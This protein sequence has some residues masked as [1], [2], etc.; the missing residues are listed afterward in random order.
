[1]PALATSVTTT[2]THTV[3]LAPRLKTRLLTHLK[4]YAG[5]HM[6]Q[7]LLDAQAKEIRE[8]L[9]EILEQA[10]ESTLAIEGHKVTL[11]APMRKKLDEKKLIALGVTL[12]QIKAATVETATTPYVRVNLP[13]TL[14][15]VEGD[16]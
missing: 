10:G 1:M 11:V 13:A 6:Q 12:E 8:K 16:E 15:D 4:T 14:D 2:A 5:I 9:G 7:K 3:K